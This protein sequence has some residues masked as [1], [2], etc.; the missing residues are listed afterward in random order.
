[1]TGFG[2]QEGKFTLSVYCEGVRRPSV[3]QELKC[4]EIVTNTTI[5]VTNVNED[6]Y[7]GVTHSTSCVLLYTLSN[8]TGEVTLSTCHDQKTFDSLIQVFR[9]TV[10][11]I[12]VDGNDDGDN[13]ASDCL[14]QYRDSG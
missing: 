12:C 7:F 10:A 6:G 2:N 3:P 8:I 1:M 14:D 4:V 5:G 11:G 13:W 9:D